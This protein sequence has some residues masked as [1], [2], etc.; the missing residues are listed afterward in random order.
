M[1]AR[2]VAPGAGQAGRPLEHRPDMNTPASRSLLGRSPLE[3]FSSLPV[4]ILLLLTL[5]IGTGEMVHGQLLRLGESMFGDPSA[6]VQYF[7]Q[8]KLKQDREARIRAVPLEGHG[9]GDFANLLDTDAFLE[10]PMERTEFEA[11]E[12]FGLWRFENYLRI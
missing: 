11:G 12:V 1:Q 8:V 4:F 2:P 7:M 6:Q 3:W 5:I 9:S 10:L